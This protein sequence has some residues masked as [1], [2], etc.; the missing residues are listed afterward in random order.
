LDRRKEM[1]KWIGLVT[2]CVALVFGV[3][4]NSEGAYRVKNSGQ[5]IVTK[6]ATINAVVAA[7]GTNKETLVVDSSDTL[8]ANLTIPSTLTLKIPQGGMIVKAS[9]YTLAINGPFE[10][11]LYQ[12]FSGFDAGDVTFDGDPQ[13]HCPE[14]W[15]AIGDGTTDD[16]IPLQ[17]YFTAIDSPVIP[18]GKTYI[19]GT[20]LTASRSNFHLTLNG[21][22]KWKA[23]TAGG[24]IEIRGAIGAYIDN[25]A[26]SGTGTID[27]NR[28][29]Q[30]GTSIRHGIGFR[31]VNGV[32]ISGIT[33]KMVGNLAG[34]AAY[35]KGI[36]VAN[37]TNVRINNN[38]LYGNILSIAI[39]EGS[40]EAPAIVL[41][42]DSGQDIQITNN[43]I[44]QVSGTYA[45]VD[46]ISAHVKRST[47]ISGNIIK[48]VTA[49]FQGIWTNAIDAGSG[50]KG[51]ISGNTLYNTGHAGIVAETDAT[52]PGA[53]YWVIT[54]NHIDTVDVE[55]IGAFGKSVIS[56]NII[57][58]SGYSGI[59]TSGGDN[60]LISGNYVDDEAGGGTL[61]IGILAYYSGG[62]TVKNISIIGNIV[63]NTT[64]IGIGISTNGATG[65]VIDGVVVANN[66]TDGD[67][68]VQKYVA[69]PPTYG[70]RYAAVIGNTYKT[71]NAGN[72]V[73]TTDGCVVQH[74]VTLP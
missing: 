34:G 40:G 66:Q 10:A 54:G 5:I 62:I 29:N 6:Y 33:I 19:V 71:W 44:D 7:A 13:N 24:I 67:M 20:Q 3:Y 17:S 4:A 69:G 65:T 53:Y 36:Y 52:T 55:G 37:C 57:L 30:T 63:K 68:I 18:A 12:V 32:S 2:L 48:N 8:A 42:A 74:N 46:A 61:D 31:Y 15:G 27:G 22:I 56:N 41:P 43:Y 23:S 47:I 28:D 1:K 73:D 60:T 64:T 26:V 72:V 9:T 38:Y 49:V 11:G 45:G 50:I 51:V 25:V 35:G 14:W 58:N 16:A 39:A 59:A 21:T 70:V